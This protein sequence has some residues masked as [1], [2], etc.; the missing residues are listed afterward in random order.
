MDTEVKEKEIKTDEEKTSGRTQIRKRRAI[1]SCWYSY[2]C[3][4]HEGGYPEATLVAVIKNE[5]E[6]PPARE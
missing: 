6:F 2:F 4:P 5:D 3:H 1:G